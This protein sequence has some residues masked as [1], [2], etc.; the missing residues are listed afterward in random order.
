[1]S[2]IDNGLRADIMRKRME[3]K[4]TLQHK[5]SLYVGTGEG[6]FTEE[7]APVN[8]DTAIFVK[9]GV[10]FLES[11]YNKNFQYNTTI[12]KYTQSIRS[13][14]DVFVEKKYS[15]LITRKVLGIVTVTYTFDL[16]CQEGD[17]IQ[18]IVQGSSNNIGFNSHFMVVVPLSI[19]HSGPMGT[20]TSYSILAEN[21]SQN[22][23]GN[24]LIRISATLLEKEDLSLYYYPANIKITCQQQFNTI[25]TSDYDFTISSFKYRILK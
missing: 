6:E 1:M 10:P 17:M 16:K 7:L 20:G 14:N 18:I 25:L 11:V 15:S 24:D 12:A 19:D 21:D 8:I 2:V 5:G 22:T 13:I 9:N 4:N 23:T 3:D